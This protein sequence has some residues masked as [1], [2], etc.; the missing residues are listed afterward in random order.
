MGQNQSHVAIFFAFSTT[1]FRPHPVLQIGKKL[2]SQY[3]VCFQ[4]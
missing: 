2:G 1:G 4:V 3:H